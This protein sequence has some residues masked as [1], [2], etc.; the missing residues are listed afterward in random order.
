M[1]SQD[2]VY[3]GIAEV[4]FRATAASQGLLLAGSQDLAVA[5]FLGILG[6]QGIQALAYRVLVEAVYRGILASQ[7]RAYLDFRDQ[8]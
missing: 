5:E 7:D 6:H 1:G 3:L 8:A 2:Q 4:E